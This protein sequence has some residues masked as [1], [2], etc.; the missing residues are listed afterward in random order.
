MSIYLEKEAEEIMVKFNYSAERVERIKKIKG[1]KWDPKRKVWRIPYSI[2]NIEEIKR[3]FRNDKVYINDEMKIFNQVEEK[4]K[5]KGYSVQTQKAYL[6][7]IKRFIDY[8]DKNLSQINESEVKEY[9]LY[10]LYLLN[11]KELTHSFVNQAI[12]S[13]KFLALEILKKKNIIIDLPRPKKESKLPQVLS[14]KEVNSILQVLDNEKHKTILYLVYSAGLRVGEVVK[15]KCED[16]DR[17]R[18]LLR[19][20]QGKGRKDRYTLLSKEALKQLKL[21]Y[22]LYKPKSWIFPGQKKGSH[23]TVRSVQRVFKK[24]CNKAEISKDVSVHSLRHSFATHL[25]ERGVDLR[26][27]QKLLGHKSSTTTEVYTHVSKNQFSKIKNPL[28]ELME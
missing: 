21:Y 1:R 15:L 16:V 12:S 24:A 23:L 11:E 2:K 18:M 14:E 13:I 5:L 7:Q 19:V 27:I 9:V 10:L 3:L 25:L 22:K 17:N 20:R 6:G 26:Y 28:D 4:L 8:T